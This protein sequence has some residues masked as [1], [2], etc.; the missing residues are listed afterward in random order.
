MRINNLPGPFISICCMTYNHENYIRQCLDGFVMQQT[1]FPFEILVHD[2]ASTDHTSSIVKEYEAKYPHLFRCVYQTENQFAKQNTLI[3]ILF[4][5]SRGKYIALCEGDDYWTDPYKLQKQVDFL[6]ANPDYVICY[7]N[8]KI[9][10]E[11]GDLISHSKLPDNLK[12]DFSSHELKTGTWVLFLTMCFRNVVNEL[13]DVFFKLMWGDTFLVSALGNYGK[14][15]YLS[16]IQ[17]AVYRKHPTSVWSSLPEIKRSYLS[18]DVYAK[19]HRYYSILKDD[20]YALYF[21]NVVIILFQKF[22]Q[23]WSGLNDDAF[24]VYFSKLLKNYRD[25]LDE[26]TVTACTGHLNR[27][28][29]KLALYNYNQNNYNDA[30]FYFRKVADLNPKH[31]T[32]FNDLGVI[33]YKTGELDKAIENFAKAFEIAPNDRDTIINCGEIF[34]S[35]EKIADAKKF[36]LN[37][38]KRNPNDE[39]IASALENLT[40]DAKEAR[41][42]PGSVSQQ[43]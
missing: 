41:E 7:H 34:K 23:R 43:E 12:R 40:R 11:A 39:V 3:N 6:E 28:F 21:K 19:L 22:I 13:P 37:Y 10:D 1:T 5:M 31:A 27:G 20:K 36:Y 15:K 24:I 4:P 33:Y 18:L 35:L 17:D 30:I 38:L 26:K 29:Y 25:I 9:I 8:A 16:N 42:Q 32:V 2:D 14:G